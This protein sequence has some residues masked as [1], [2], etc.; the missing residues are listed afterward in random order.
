MV[1][2][3]DDSALPLP[4][5]DRDVVTSTVPEPSP[6]AGVASVE[7]VMD[8]AACQYVDFPGIG[9]IDLDTP[10]L[11]RNIREM[12]EVAT[13]RMFAEPSIL[14]T[15]ASVASELHQYEGSG[16]SALR[17]VL[18]KA[19]G[20]LEESTTGTELAVVVSPPSPIREGAGSSLPQ[21]AE[22]VAAAPAASVVGVAEGVVGEVGPSS[23]R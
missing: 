16:S 21:P 13:E 12:L 10:E 15:I 11:P 8:L 6:A 18:E 20:V 4:A 5:G 17:V 3:D 23:P 2:A 14:D 22:V 7:D 19:E 9:T 1:P